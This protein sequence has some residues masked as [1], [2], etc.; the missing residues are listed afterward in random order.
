MKKLVFVLSFIALSVQAE[1]IH[2]KVQGMVCSLC[3]QGLTKK[4]GAEKSVSKVKVDMDEKMVTI[5]TKPE[6]TVNDQTIKTIVED[7]GVALVSIH[8]MNHE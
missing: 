1:V 2:V 5:T 7:N 6:Q 3:S 8:R 4:F